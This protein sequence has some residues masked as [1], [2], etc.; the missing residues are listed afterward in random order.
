MGSNAGQLCGR[1]ESGVI[2]HV[3]LLCNREI[4][5]PP[6]SLGIF[7]NCPAL[8]QIFQ[9]QRNSFTSVLLSSGSRLFPLGSPGQ[10]YFESPFLSPSI[11]WEGQSSETS[12]L[13]L[14]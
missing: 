3:V 10:D 8:S 2:L 7:L 11:G 6:H 1:F 12:G 4:A 9:L 14:H 13:V 5:S